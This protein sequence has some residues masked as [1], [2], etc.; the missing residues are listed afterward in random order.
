MTDKRQQERERFV[1]NRLW[2]DFAE[3]CHTPNRCA[4][5]Q[6]PASCEDC[7]WSADKV[8]ESAEQAADKFA[9]MEESK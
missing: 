3:T 5:Y 9:A 6:L 4:K 1:H 8:I 7:G 2:A